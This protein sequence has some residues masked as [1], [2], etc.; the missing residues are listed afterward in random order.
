MEAGSAI[1]GVRGLVRLLRQLGSRVPSLSAGCL[2]TSAALLMVIK[3]FGIFKKN[4]FL[5]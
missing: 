4:V 1:H 3:T 5:Y 2:E